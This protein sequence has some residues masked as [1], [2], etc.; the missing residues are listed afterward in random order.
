MFPLFS[1]ALTL[2]KSSNFTLGDL[3]TCIY[4]FIRTI[5]NQCS[6]CSQWLKMKKIQLTLQWE[7]SYSTSMYIFLPTFISNILTVLSWPY[8]KKTKF[9]FRDFQPY[10]Y[11]FSS[12]IIEQGS[13]CS[14]W[15]KGKKHPADFAV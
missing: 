5:I 3:E 13:H 8:I 15:P 1:V 2:K 11:V 4:V 12:T 9:A 14:Q 6:H 10:I 7:T